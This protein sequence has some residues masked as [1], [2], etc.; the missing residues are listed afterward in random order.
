MSVETHSEPGE[1]RKLVPT[2]TSSG[3]VDR[4]LGATDAARLDTT[5]A[6]H[7]PDEHTPEREGAIHPRGPTDAERLHDNVTH[8][9]PEVEIPGPEEPIRPRGPTGANQQAGNETQYPADSQPLEPTAA[10]QPRG[11]AGADRPQD[12][13]IGVPAHSPAP[14]RPVIEVIERRPPGEAAPDAR[15][16]AIQQRIRADA[17]A[18]G[19]QQL[20]EVCADHGVETDDRIQAVAEAR[21]V[22]EET[23][24]PFIVEASDRIGAGVSRELAKRPD[25][26]VSFVYRDGAMIATTFQQLH[27]DLYRVG[28][29][30]FLSRKNAEAVLQDLEDNAGQNFGSLEKFRDRLSVDP[31]QVPGAMLRTQRHV[32]SAGVPITTPGSHHILIDSGHRGTVQERLAAAYPRSTFSGH[33]LFHVESEFDPHPGTKN[34]YALHLSRDRS[35]P[36]DPDDPAMIYKDKDPATVVEQLF[37]GL[38]STTHGYDDRGTPI[39]ERERPSLDRINPLVVAPHYQDATVRTAIMAIAPRTVANYARMVADFDRAGIDYRPTLTEQARTCTLRVRS[40]AYGHD[41][42]D[43]AFDALADSFVPRQDK[44]LVPRLRAIAGDPG[45]PAAT[46]IWLGYQG[47]PLADKERYIAAQERTIHPQDPARPEGTS[48][49]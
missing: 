25:A 9:R 36:T 33:Y 22:M 38:M 46:A 10:I 8:H 23:L 35:Y 30:I 40:W 5:E 2:A 41:D 24:T 14:A 27:P 31:D 15:L 45:P 19:D 48:H 39:R 11:L 32:L 7:R 21:D 4:D 12:A 29:P 34:G 26:T 47:L 18:R 1:P 13:E 43:P 6:V 3:A 20:E 49:G 17:A 16:E 28:H 42:G 44:N 37:H